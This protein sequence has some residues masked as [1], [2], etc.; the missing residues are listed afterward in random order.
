MRGAI[1]CGVDGLFFEAHPDPSRALSD[2][3]TQLP[4]DR[5]EPFLDDALR[6]HQAVTV[7]THA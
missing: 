2:A 3:A 6:V 1:A 4:L 7:A 5:V